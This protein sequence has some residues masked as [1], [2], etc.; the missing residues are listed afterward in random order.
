MV[1]FFSQVVPRFKCRQGGGGKEEAGNPVNSVRND[2]GGKRSWTSKQNSRR[3]LPVI[4]LEVDPKKRLN[5]LQGD[6]YYRGTIC[7]QIKWG[8]AWHYRKC[9]DDG[10]GRWTINAI[11]LGY[12]L[13]KIV[14][15]DRLES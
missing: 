2:R 15:V 6:D 4:P 10:S 12:C 9:H 5:S 11:V 14:P 3:V 1:V 8:S 7:P 13:A